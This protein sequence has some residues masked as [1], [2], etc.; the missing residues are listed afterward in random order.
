MNVFNNRNK[1]MVLLLFIIIM[2]EWWGWRLLTHGFNLFDA[3]LINE[4]MTIGAA[5]YFGYPVYSDTVLVTLLILWPAIVY[6]LIT[7][8]FTHNI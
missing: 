1:I 7:K 8:L 5:H 4:N 6:L 3:P 2:G